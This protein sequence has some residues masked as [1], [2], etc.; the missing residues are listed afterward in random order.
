MLADAIP[1]VFIDWVPAVIDVAFL[2]LALVTRLV[3]VV[4]G[5]ILQYFL[6]EHPWLTLFGGNNNAHILDGNNNSLDDNTVKRVHVASPPPKNCSGPIRVERPGGWQGV[7][8]IDGATASHLAKVSFRY[9]KKAFDLV[10]VQAD[11]LVE[12]YDSSPLHRISFHG[13]LSMRSKDGPI[14]AVKGDPVKGYLYLPE[15]AVIRPLRKLGKSE[16][17]SNKIMALKC[18]FVDEN[19]EL[20]YIQLLILLGKDAEGVLVG[21]YNYLNNKN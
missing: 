13:H 17:S 8:E 9:K 16:G 2:L 20:E 14:R 3:N 4:T 10:H 19:D 12:R 6:N 7:R 5:R 1:N 21:T 11:L 15:S 18:D